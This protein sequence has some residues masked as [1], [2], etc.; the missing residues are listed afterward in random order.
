MIAYQIWQHH[1]TRAILSS[2]GTLYRLESLDSPNRLSLLYRDLS[3]VLH[4]FSTIVWP[5][6]GRTPLLLRWHW[7]KRYFRAWASCRCHQGLAHDRTCHQWLPLTAMGQSTLYPLLTWLSSSWLAAS[8]WVEVTLSTYLQTLLSFLL[9]FCLSR[10]FGWRI[11][12]PWFCPFKHLP[13]YFPAHSRNHHLL[14]LW[15]LGWASQFCLKVA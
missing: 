5:T 6:F 10:R 2:C 7:Y 4:S 1:N 3:W 12:M 8:A 13:W 14:L 15:L 9:H 11:R